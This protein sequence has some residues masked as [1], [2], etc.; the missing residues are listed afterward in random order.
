[1]A[2]FQKCAWWVDWESPSI[3]RF[4]QIAHVP[5]KIGIYT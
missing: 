1:M 4:P 2:L 3:I 5:L